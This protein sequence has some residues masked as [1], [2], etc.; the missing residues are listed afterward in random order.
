MEWAGLYKLMEALRQTRQGSDFD[1][2]IPCLAGFYASQVE[3]I[4]EPSTEAPQ[5]TLRTS[6]LWLFVVKPQERGQVILG[7]VDRYNTFGSMER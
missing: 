3:Q 2:F 4:S 7:R 6:Y 5:K 1:P